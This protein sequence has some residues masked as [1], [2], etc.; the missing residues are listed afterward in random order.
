MKKAT[1]DVY[2]KF[3]ERLIYSIDH[4]D[5]KEE[6]AAKM[7]KL[8]LSLDNQFPK[9]TDDV[10]KYQKQVHEAIDLFERGEISDF[11]LMEKIRDIK[12]KVR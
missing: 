5:W 8:L 9:W 1:Y 3:L 11:E 10:L 12:N 2:A 7:T 4:V 6:R